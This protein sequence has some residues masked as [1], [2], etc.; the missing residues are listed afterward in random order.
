VKFFPF[1]WRNLLRNKLRSALTGGAIA[2]AIALVCILRTM[3]VGF[4]NFLNE[5]A[6]NTRI[7]IHNTAGIV[8]SMPYAY[9]SRVKSVPGVVNAVS[10]TW[11]GGAVDKDK[12]VTF[13]NFAVDGDAIGEVFADLDIAPE[14]LEHFRTHRDGLLVGRMTMKKY[15][16]K[17]GDQVTLASNVWP[18]ELSFTVSGEI[19]SDQ[20]PRAWMQREYFVEAL[21]GVWGTQC[22]SC[23]Q[24][25]M[26]WARVDDPDRVPGVMS[27]IDTMFRNSEAETAS[28]TEKSFFQNFFGSLQGFV[29]VILIVTG[30]VTLCIVFIAANTASMAVRERLRELAVLKAIGFRWQLL[31]GTLVGEAALLSTAAGAVGALASLGLTELLGAAAGWN[32]QLG[33]LSGFIV[34]NAILVQALFLAFFVGILSG[35]VPSFGAARRS[36]ASTLRDVF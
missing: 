27:E 29:T 3:P 30:L 4:D 11:F 35:V 24:V 7:S 25:G 15:G 32:P 20:D 13:P 17:P 21:R 6:T 31:F 1:V 28:E 14:A 10:W 2:L 36:V 19:P 23:D 16:W 26:I 9:L 8:Y 33:P 18:L 5:L 34:T 22:S 12:G